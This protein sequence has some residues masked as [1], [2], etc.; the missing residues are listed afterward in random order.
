[1]KYTIHLR[2]NSF[3]ALRDREGLPGV[4]N[5]LPYFLIERL[6]EESLMFKLDD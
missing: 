1:M 4:S 2:A 5:L 6:S 3:V